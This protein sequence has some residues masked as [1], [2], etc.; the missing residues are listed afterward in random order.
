VRR[1]RGYSIGA[2]SSREKQKNKNK[3]RTKMNANSTRTRFRFVR[4]A[5]RMHPVSCAYTSHEVAN[6]DG[7]FTVTVNIAASFCHRKDHFDRA[8]GRSIAEGRLAKHPATFTFT[9][10]PTE[11]YN[12][13]LN[14][15]VSDYVAS[16]GS[17]IGSNL[18]IGR[19]TNTDATSEGYVVVGSSD[20]DSQYGSA[21]RSG[22]TFELHSEG[23][24]HI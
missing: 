9:R 13:R 7:T 24:S 4:V 22:A 6:D 21:D 16:C 10:L 14:L 3:E 8:L 18:G 11:N 12:I 19:R 5:R 1:L 15:A 2:G 17:Q 20:V 23:Y